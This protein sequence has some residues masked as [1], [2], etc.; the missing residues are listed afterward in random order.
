MVNLFMLS[1]A[2][3]SSMALPLGVLRRV[4]SS[5]SSAM[6]HGECMH[7]WMLAAART[8]TRGELAGTDSHAPTRERAATCEH[9]DAC[10]RAGC[11]VVG[12]RRR[13][14]YKRIDG[15]PNSIDSRPHIGVNESHKIGNSGIHGVTEY[16]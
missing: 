16:F 14:T 15:R 9:T 8:E 10:E 5:K 4:T 2:V 13:Y 11:R 1:L 3:T 6:E 12:G 7:G